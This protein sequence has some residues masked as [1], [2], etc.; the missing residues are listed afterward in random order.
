MEGEQTKSED[1]EIMELKEN[2]V[3]QTTKSGW[4]VKSVWKA[5]MEIIQIILIGNG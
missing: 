4:G 3:V 5:T 2:E 1:G